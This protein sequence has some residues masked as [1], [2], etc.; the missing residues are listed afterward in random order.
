MEK[1]VAQ[2][3]NWFSNQAFLDVL[4]DNDPKAMTDLVEDVFCS[5]LEE[6]EE[7]GLC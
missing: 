4:S 2:V 3:L 7:Q 6:Q 1:G 5:T